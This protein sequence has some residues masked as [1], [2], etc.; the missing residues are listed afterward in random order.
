MTCI[1]LIKIEYDQCKGEGEFWS[2]PDAFYGKIVPFSGDSEVPPINIKGMSGGPL[3]SIERKPDKGFLY[4]LYGIQ[5]SWES[6]Q[7]II[8]AESIYKIQE[9]IEAKMVWWPHNN[10]FHLTETPLRFVSADEGH[11]GLQ[12]GI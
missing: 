12:M 7:R 5:R 9:I 4:R 1:P 6:R 3:L 11:V 10:P 8:R 2:D